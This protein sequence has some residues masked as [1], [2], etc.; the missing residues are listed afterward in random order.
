M[1]IGQLTV[2]QSI[3]CTVG[4]SP[5]RAACTLESSRSGVSTFAVV[6]VRLH[7]GTVVDVLFAVSTLPPII[8]FACVAK[9]NVSTVSVFTGACETIVHKIC[10]TR[11]IPV[12]RG[13]C[14]SKD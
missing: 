3:L 12:S 8:T 2:I 14:T 6:A 11:C 1:T 7:N 13:A 5:A 10:G 4:T 9:A